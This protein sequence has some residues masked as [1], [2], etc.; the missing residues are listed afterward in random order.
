MHKYL[1]LYRAPAA[2]RKQ[3]A[4]A[5]PEQAKAGM[6]AW[7]SWAKR[8][9]T[10]LVDMGAPLGAA[11]GIAGK[12]VADDLGGYSVLQ[13]ESLDAV[14]KHFEGHPHLQMPGGTIEVF[15]FVKLPG[16]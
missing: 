5:S 4:S 11:I 13:A 1:A 6:D 14:K 10:A 15:E 7:M 16:M 3:M 12:P 2:S 9:G 8:T